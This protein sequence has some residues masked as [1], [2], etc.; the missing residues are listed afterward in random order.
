MRASFRKNDQELKV[1]IQGQTAFNTVGM[2]R[3]AALDG[4][5]LA[6]LLEDQVATAIE[7]GKLIRGFCRTGAGSALHITSI[8]RAAGSTRRRLHS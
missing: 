1:R 6:Y 8:V 2:M 3:K 5:G 7:E 4:F